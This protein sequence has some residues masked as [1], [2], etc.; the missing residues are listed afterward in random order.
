MVDYV[1]EYVEKTGRGAQDNQLISFEHVPGFAFRAGP[2]Y[3]KR[4]DI[5]SDIGLEVYRIVEEN[6]RIDNCGNQI[7]RLEKIE[8]PTELK[9]L[10]EELLN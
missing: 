2:A 3:R 6:L 8:D 7:S 4:A 9:D 5:N 10:T 1:E